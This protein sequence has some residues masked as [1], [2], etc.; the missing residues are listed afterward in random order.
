VPTEGRTGGIAGEAYAAFIEE[1]LKQEH[2]R[3]TAL[4]QRGLSV[5]TTSGT[6][7]TLL[8]GI[9]A[10]LSQD[11]G[12]AISALAK[13]FLVAGLLLFLVALLLGLTIGRPMAR[14]FARTRVQDLRQA[15]RPQAWG[16]D[17][18]EAVRRIA[19]RRVDELDS[20]RDGN[21]IK[22]GYLFWALSA[23]TVALACV[24]FAVMTI[25]LA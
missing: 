13:G 9:A 21:G 5:V 14:F 23:E 4:E 17:K 16:A 20:W 22:A 18:P 24:A 2:A 8:F 7:I 11:N 25:V 10:F 15:V 6:L 1:L 3:K 12:L 19:E